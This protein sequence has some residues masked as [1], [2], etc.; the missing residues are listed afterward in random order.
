VRKISVLYNPKENE[1]TSKQASSSDAMAALNAGF[2]NVKDGGSATYIKTSGS[3]VDSDTAKKWLKNI[4]MTGAVMINTI[5]HVSI[6]Q[7]M[8][9][10]WYDTHTEFPDVL[11]TGPLLLKDRKKVSLN[12]TSLVITKHPRSCIGV[13]NNHKIILVAIDG[14]TADA[15]G[16]TLFK[17]TDLMISLRCK[18]AVNLDGGGSTTMWINGKPFNGVVNMPC[19]NKKF[20]HE[21]ERAVSDIF[22]IK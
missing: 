2:F 1:K 14:R 16:M 18:D 6:N 4:N 17:L 9:N 12:R 15:Q 8:P 7:A 11:V 20:D 19:D 10:A 3:I 22:I 21:G 5:G 13:L